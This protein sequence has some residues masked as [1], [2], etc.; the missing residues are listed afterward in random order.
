MV[1]IDKIYFIVFFIFLSIF[2][3]YLLCQFREN[4][5]EFRSA[6]MVS[7]M[8]EYFKIVRN[9]LRKRLNKNPSTFRIMR[10]VFLCYAITILYYFTSS[11]LLNSFR[12]SKVF[13][14]LK[15]FNFNLIN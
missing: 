11:L 6:L 5:V 3:L 2:G 9:F 8:N 7:R 10:I 13:F 14:F 12:I 15:F 1:S 4:L